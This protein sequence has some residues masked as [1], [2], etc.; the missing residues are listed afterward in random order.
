[1]AGS[2]KCRKCGAVN[3]TANIRV[4]GMS[5]GN[6]SFSSQIAN[7]QHAAHDAEQKMQAE[8]LHCGARRSLFSRIF[9]G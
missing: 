6:T 1:M 4:S 7:M 8:C 9:S 2:W 5:Y 3:S